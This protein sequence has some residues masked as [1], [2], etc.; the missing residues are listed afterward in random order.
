MTANHLPP[1]S[2]IGDLEGGEH[3]P[4]SIEFAKR[5]L[6]MHKV[7]SKRKE[8]IDR[9]AQESRL[10]T[11]ALRIKTV[12]ETIN[13]KELRIKAIVVEAHYNQKITFCSTIPIYPVRASISFPINW[14]R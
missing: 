14:L 11:K 1:E 2:W 4:Q 10:H 9:E 3:H 7:E 13:T 6:R 8:G 5:K 12:V